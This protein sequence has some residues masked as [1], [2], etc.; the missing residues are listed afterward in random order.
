MLALHYT[1]WVGPSRMVPLLR[2]ERG[3]VWQLLTGAAAGERR[4]AL[5][6]THPGGHQTRGTVHGENRRASTSGCSTPASRPPTRMRGCSYRLMTPW[7]HNQQVKQ[8]TIRPAAH[9]RKTN[10]S[11]GA[12][13]L[14]AEGAARHRL[15]QTE[16]AMK[17]KLAA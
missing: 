4:Y 2:C 13:R 1:S 11:P 9:Q 17:Y 6:G 16:V 3:N 12:S 7:G 5:A 14:H 15:L 8:P 10:S